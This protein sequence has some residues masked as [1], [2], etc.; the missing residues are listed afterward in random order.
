MTC[1]LFDLFSLLT[2]LDTLLEP[3]HV[4]FSVVRSATI[5]Q[6]SFSVQS[7]SEREK[8]TIKHCFCYFWREITWLK[9]HQTPVRILPQ[10]IIAMVRVGMR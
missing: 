2:M 6:T 4:L 5:H 8:Q 9:R 7:P 1:Y 3:L 10:A